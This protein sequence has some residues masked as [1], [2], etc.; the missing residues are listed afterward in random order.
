LGDVKDG[1][2]KMI[3]FS[4]LTDVTVDGKPMKSK[5]VLRLT[6]SKLDADITSKSKEK[7]VLDFFA[8]QDFSDYPFSE[9][10]RDTILDVFDEANKNKFTVQIQYA[11]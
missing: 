3:L 7:D 11:Q 9:K 1:I 2:L 8:V 5:A 4:N 10:E 6:S